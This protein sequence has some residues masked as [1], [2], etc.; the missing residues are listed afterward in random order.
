MASRPVK[1]SSRLRHWESSEYALA[2]TSGSR[3]F[4]AFSAAF[5]FARA[6]S[7]VKGGKIG[8][9]T[10]WGVPAEDLF[11]VISHLP[12]VFPCC[13]FIAN[14]LEEL[15]RPAGQCPINAVVPHAIE[16]NPRVSRTQSQSSSGSGAPCDRTCRCCASVLRKP[17]RI[18]SHGRSVSSTVAVSASPEAAKSYGAMV[19][20]SLPTFPS[21]F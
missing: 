1:N 15:W 8:V 19:G 12:C 5:T 16:L 11:T 2:T 13:Q 6:V 3:V 18:A 7:S 17:L 4:H 9:I 20:E 21:P 14:L 10:V